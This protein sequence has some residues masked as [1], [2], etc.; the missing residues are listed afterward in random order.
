MKQAEEDE[1]Y[2]VVVVVSHRVWGCFVYKKGKCYS[3]LLSVTQ[4]SAPCILSTIEICPVHNIHHSFPFFCFNL[5]KYCILKEVFSN[6]LILNYNHNQ[7][8]PLILHLY[9]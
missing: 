7:H 3:M 9:F 2:F 1:K 4:A 5:F 6:Y 8:H